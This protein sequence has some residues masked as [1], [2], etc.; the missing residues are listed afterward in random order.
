[1]K[2]IVKILTLVICFA[3]LFTMTSCTTTEEGYKSADITKAE[4]LYTLNVKISE[5]NNVVV[6]TKANDKKFD[7]VFIAYLDTT[8][9]IYYFENTL[10]EEEFY[11]KTL[12]AVYLKDDAV[13]KGTSF[14]GFLEKGEK[15]RL[16]TKGSSTTIE[17]KE[18]IFVTPE[19]AEKEN[20]FPKVSKDSLIFSGW[21]IDEACTFGNRVATVDEALEAFNEALEAFEKA[22]ESESSVVFGVLYARYITFGEGAVV[23]RTIVGEGVNIAAGA[24]VGEADSKEIKLQAENVR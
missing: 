14:V 2:R 16:Y 3:F 7:G 17:G 13:P 22:Q 18:V 10:L 12:T 20:S 24:V 5:E 23:T 15:V 1:M 6:N 8:T 11:G 19:G 21:Y 4:N 9:N